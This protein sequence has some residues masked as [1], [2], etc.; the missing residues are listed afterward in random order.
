MTIFALDQNSQKVFKKHPEIRMNIQ[1]GMEGSYSNQQFY[2]VL[3]S[4]LAIK[5]DESKPKNLGQ[6]AEIFRAPA[7]EVEDKWKK[8]AEDST[9]QIGLA[10]IPEEKTVEALFLTIAGSPPPPPGQLFP[11]PPL[12]MPAAP[13]SI[14]GHLPFS[15]ST[16]PDDVYY[17]YESFPKSRRIDPDTKEILPGTYAAPASELFFMPTGLSAVARQALPSLMP[18]RWR[19]ELQPV[20][21]T[22]IR[23]GA[24]VP[25]YGQ[26]GGGVEVRFEGQ[27]LPPGSPAINRGPIADPV[28]LPIL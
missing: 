16:G 28:I 27:G 21:G 17:R 6:V 9:N 13:A 23:Y 8:W 12:P 14:Y 7:N 22:R 18:A 1:V 11:S 20:A 19:W 26:S 4:R 10:P 25:L 5:F 15:T 2:L 3:G 24:S